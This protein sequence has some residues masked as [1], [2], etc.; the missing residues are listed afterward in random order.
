MFASNVASADNASSAADAESGQ[1]SWSGKGSRSPLRAESFVRVSLASASA[2]ASRALASPFSASVTS[3]GLPVCFARAA[4]SR[5]ERSARRGS[6]L[7]KSAASPK[8]S[9]A[10]RC[11]A[12]TR[13]AFSASSAAA[14]WLPSF[15]F[16]AARFAWYP[17]L[18]GSNLAASVNAACASR[19]RRSAYAA[20]PRS[21]SASARAS[22]YSPSFHQGRT[23]PG[24]L[25]STAMASSAAVESRISRSSAWTAGRSRTPRHLARH[26]RSFSFSARHDVPASLGSAQGRTSCGGG[27]DAGMASSAMF[28][29]I[30]AG[31]EDARRV[32]PSAPRRD[33][34]RGRAGE[35]T[36]KENARN[37]R[38]R[39]LKERS[40]THLVLIFARLGLQERRREREAVQAEREVRDDVLLRA[41]SL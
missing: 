10:L 39:T 9:I 26:T 4:A 40:L 28:A 24:A 23:Y 36:A 30:H 5:K 8:R 15:R 6:S 2:T 37:R 11:V 12:S 34:C 14:R 27:S 33:E 31:H 18:L 1:D 41:V 20:I 17:A 16:A 29:T 3:R 21:F 19:K 38:V 7:P 13:S 32:C 25:C 22:S 35:E